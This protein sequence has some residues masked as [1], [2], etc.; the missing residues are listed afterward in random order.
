M[1]AEMLQKYIFIFNI[2]YLKNYIYLYS[3][4]KYFSF[5]K[6]L[7]FKEN[8]FIFSQNILLL[9]RFFYPT[10]FCF[11]KEIYFYSVKKKRV[12]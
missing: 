3:T 1:V 6:M 11:V 7:S 2:F 12:Q 4:K 9:K 10:G 8:I 5:V